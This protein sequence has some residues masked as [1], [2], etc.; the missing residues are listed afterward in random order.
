ML[1]STHERILEKEIVALR[2]FEE[3]AALRHEALTDTLVNRLVDEMAKRD[4]RSSAEIAAEYFPTPVNASEKVVVK[5]QSA[6]P[7]EIRQ[8][9]GDEVVA[10]AQSHRNQHGRRS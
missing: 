4:T 9:S 8:L 7:V 2:A 6:P 5:P 1:R 10:R 3:E